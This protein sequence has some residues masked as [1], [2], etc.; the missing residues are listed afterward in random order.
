MSRPIVDFRNPVDTEDST[1]APE[2]VLAGST[3]AQVRNHYADASGRFFAGQW[4]STRGR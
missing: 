1:P 3:R 4:S 2:R